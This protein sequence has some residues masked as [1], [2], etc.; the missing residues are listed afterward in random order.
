MH[1]EPCSTL[2][3]SAWWSVRDGS[4][5][6][7]LAQLYALTNGSMKASRWAPGARCE[8]QWKSKIVASVTVRCIRSA[9]PLG[10]G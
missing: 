7:C 8:R 6:G 5:F 4:P 2:S 10:H 1:Y 3:K 9:G